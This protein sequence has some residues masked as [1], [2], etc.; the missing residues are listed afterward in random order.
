MNLATEKGGNQ[1]LFALA[2]NPNVG[3][4]TLFNYLTGL[5][6][7]TGNWAGKTVETSGGRGKRFG[8]GY[9]LEDL[10]GCYSLSACSPEEELARDYIENGGADAVIVVVDAARLE[11][12]L[13]LVLMILE[14]TSKVVIA[15]N[16]VR[17]AKKRGV[18]VDTVKLGDMLGVPAVEIDARR[19]EGVRD[20]I[21]A[22]FSVSVGN[23]DRLSESDAGTEMGSS[24]SRSEKAALVANAC[25]KREGD[26]I[27]CER[28]ADK[29][30]TGRFCGFAVMALLVAAVFAVT[31]YGANYPSA[32][33]ARLFSA[34]G[35]GLRGLLTSVGVKGAF[36][37]F[38]ADG[39]YDPLA[40]VISVML[41]PMAIFFPFF[42]FLEDLGY[43]P[44]VAYNLDR[45][46]QKC[47]ACGK[48]A[49]TMCMGLGCSAVGVTG[50]RIIDSPRERL[51]AV[52]TN[53]MVPCNGK[54][55]SLIAVTAAFFA[56]ASGK[57]A[58]AAILS[59]MVF[60]CVG[61]TVLTSLLL[62]STVLRGVPSS[63]ILELPPYRKPDLSKV[64]VRSVFDR[65]L[66]VLGRA[67]AVAA[68]AGAL[69]WILSSFA[70]G[71]VSLLSRFT[72]FLDPAGRAMGL[73][74]VLLA[75]FILGAPANEIVLPV[76]LM[77][78]SAGAG[79]TDVPVAA[80]LRNVLTASG[81]SGITPVCFSVFMLFHFPCTT[82]LIT[83]AK[84]T[85][86]AKWTFAAAAVPTIVGI[87]L[88]CAVNGIYSLLS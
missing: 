57:I 33:L 67:A 85:K 42:T 80:E 30:L 62:S 38:I 34:I 13:C 44:R 20:L 7:H 73:D 18:F 46:F 65:T 55:P 48:Q 45:V 35:S 1:K 50:C 23:N 8:G 51:I 87:A 17:E 82:T 52:L 77:A 37:S 88:C 22:A 63:F 64:L 66:F 74:G 5:K 21:A 27:R 86:S 32:L 76:A 12:N 56:V 68:P 16:L 43:L 72:A 31:V 28:I 71:G 79:L 58:S 2:G 54:F 14:I 53:C 84:E 78:Y 69:I 26:S 25:V 81:W 49:I 60:L 40:W 3:K 61:M 75:A 36:A 39:V 10:P 24:V 19:G 70:P 15:V 9:W 41:P 6:H 4:S 11:R 83:I 59:G 29:Y 47:S